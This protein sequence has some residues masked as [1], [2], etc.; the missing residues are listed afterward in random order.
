VRI[1]CC[2]YRTYKREF[3]TVDFRKKE[4]FTVIS[5]VDRYL[6]LCLRYSIKPKSWDY[7]IKN[8][9]ASQRYHEWL[10]FI[11]KPSTTGTIFSH[12]SCNGSIT[13]SFSLAS[14]AAWNA[15]ASSLLQCSVF[16]ATAITFEPN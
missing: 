12:P 10:P 3:I 8:S 14:Y 16:S 4:I 9:R 13:G 1:P 11:I 6:L 7:K 5:S 2:D 15:N